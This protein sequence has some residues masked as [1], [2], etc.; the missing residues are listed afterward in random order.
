M[1]G[2]TSQRQVEVVYK[3]N[4]KG[5]QVG[6]NPEGKLARPNVR[7]VSP[8]AM[9][10]LSFNCRGAGNAPIVHDLENVSKL[11]NISLMFLC[12]TRQNKDRIS[13]LRFRLGLKGFK[14]F[15]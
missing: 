5:I 1:D 6:A 8:G 13:R 10:C 11:H 9:N 7:L 12:E 14:G 15:Q 4:K 2:K 3:R